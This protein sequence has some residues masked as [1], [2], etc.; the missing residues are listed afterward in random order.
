MSIFNWIKETWVIWYRWKQPVVYNSSESH[1]QTKPTLHW[2]GGVGGGVGVG[3]GEGREREKEVER[4]VSVVNNM[5]SF[6]I[7]TSSHLT[8]GQAMRV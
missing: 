5:W 6:I 4:G 1:K 8:G 7:K 2:G 3:G